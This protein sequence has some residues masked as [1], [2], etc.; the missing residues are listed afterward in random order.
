[1]RP[2]TARR[3]RYIV[4]L[5]AVEAALLANLIDQLRTLITERR[6]QASDDPLAA[7]TG[8]AMGPATAP[9]D[10]AMARLLPAFHRADAELSAG[11]RMLREPEV[12]AAKYDAAAA[13]R[14]S[15]PEAGGTIRL[16]EPAARSWLLTLNDI[17]LI[18]GVRLSITEDEPI[19]ATVRA[20]PTGG[21]H[22]M[23][24]TYQWLTALQESLAQALLGQAA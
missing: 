13:M 8:V 11:L 3:G 23:F 15:L 4:T 14:A 21:E 12:L 6:Q 24:V 18:L 17:R 5:A 16:D 2:F 19:P 9:E 10:P 20:D 1:M 7:L 22:A